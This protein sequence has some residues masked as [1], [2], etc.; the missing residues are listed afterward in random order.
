M[1][2]KE[3]KVERR[4]ERE[5]GR[6][7]GGRERKGEKTKRNKEKGGGGLGKKMV[8]ENKGN[9]EAERSCASGPIYRKLK[10]QNKY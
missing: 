9:N 10:Q 3:K 4:R 1:I 8:I 2:E 5:R 6:E 7:R